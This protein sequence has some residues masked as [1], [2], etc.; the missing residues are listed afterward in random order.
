[1]STY[2][3]KTNI[4][5]G[6]CVA[7]VTPELNELQG[8]DEWKVDTSDKD[9]TLTASGKD[10]DQDQVMQAVKRAG[11]TATPKK[12]GILNTLFGKK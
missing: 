12:G 3:F 9:K 7:K 10:L 2:K 8:L 6:N 11:F 1:M 5:C 4:N